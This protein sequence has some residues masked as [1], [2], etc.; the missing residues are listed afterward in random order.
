MPVFGIRQ[1][2][3]ASVTGNQTDR[4]TALTEQTAYIGSG[5]F[6]VIAEGFI[7]LPEMA[8]TESLWS[9]YAVQMR[10]VR[11]MV[12]SL[13]VIG[14]CNGIRFGNSRR[15]DGILLHGGDTVA[16]DFIRDKRTYSIVGKYQRIGRT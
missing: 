11:K 2:D 9:L 15:T 14:P 16:D 12:G 5:G 8:D 3:I 10:S 6:P 1:F 13:G 4:Q 7:N